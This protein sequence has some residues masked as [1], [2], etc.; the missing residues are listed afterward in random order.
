MTK[1]E[2]LKGLEKE[3]NFLTDFEKKEVLQDQEEFI[4]EAMSQGKTEQE[5]LETLGSSKAFAESVRL[6][7]K[8]KRIQEAPST[9]SSVKE[10]LTAVGILFGLM[11]LSLLIIF[12]P[13]LV[14]L[15]LLFSW[16]TV[17]LT[18]LVF[19]LFCVPMSFFIFF[20][21]FGVMGFLGVFFV[22][23]GVLLGALASLALLFLLVGFIVELF[24]YYL[25]WNISL[26][27]GR[28][29]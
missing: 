17:S 7:H 22:S 9:W 3:L 1:E 24:V 6:E 15:G 8:V 25:N 14:L 18:V 11:P 12:G 23:L 16:F 29:V 5:V 20:F 21:G 13:G 4:K 28:L 27:K 10:S 26:V 2:F 19:A